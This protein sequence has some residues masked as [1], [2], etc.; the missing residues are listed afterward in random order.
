[1]E[2]TVEFLSRL[3]FAAT[4]MFHYIFPPFSIGLGLMLVIFESYYFITKDKVYENITRFWIKIFA[5]NFLLELPQ[6]LC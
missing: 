3:Q 6:G 5:A 2:Y 4:A 1:M